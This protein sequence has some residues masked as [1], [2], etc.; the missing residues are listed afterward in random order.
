[1]TS[2]DAR[3]PI[4]GDRR[5][6]NRETA[7]MD[8]YCRNHGWVTVEWRNPNLL[9]MD[10]HR[11]CVPALDTV[12]DAVAV[13]DQ[14]RDRYEWVSVFWDRGWGDSGE[15]AEI[16]IIEDG[17]GQAPRAYITAS[18]YERLVVSGTVA[19]NSLRTFKARKLHDYKP[20]VDA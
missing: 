3:A 11:T 18:V 7:T 13:L 12:E 5:N 8:I 19:P 2:T 17:N 1:M 20:A 10:D 9:F 14:L 6:Q 16:S 4:H 15:E